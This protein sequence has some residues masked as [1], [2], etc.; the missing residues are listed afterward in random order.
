[1]RKARV[2]GTE[3]ECV[4]CGKRVHRV[5]K[6]VVEGKRSDVQIFGTGEA[7]ATK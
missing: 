7:G 4:G 3:S 6:A 1:M 5:P 2:A